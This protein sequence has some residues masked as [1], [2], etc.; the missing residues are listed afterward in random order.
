[1][2]GDI[3]GVVEEN[4]YQESLT[5]EDG[6]GSLSDDAKSVSDSRTP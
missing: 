5:E 4:E 6:V 2:R 1:M 3:R